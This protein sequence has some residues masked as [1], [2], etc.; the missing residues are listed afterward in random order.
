MNTLRLVLALTA[1]VGSLRAVAGDLTSI[2]RSILK[3]PRYA[4]RSPKYCLLV[5]GPKAKTRIWLVLDGK[6]LYVDRNGNGDLTEAGKRV[7]GKDGVFK[8][9]VLLDPVTGHKHTDLIVNVDR[10]IERSDDTFYI[11]PYEI[12]GR[13]RGKYVFTATPG[14]ADRAKDAPAVPL[15]GPLTPR[16]FGDAGLTLHRDRDTRL[17][18]HLIGMGDKAAIY[19]EYDGIPAEVRPHVEIECPGKT[20]GDGPVRST[21]HLKER[22]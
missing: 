19:V 16:I 6:T 12:T 10:R 2:D 5:L 11:Q 9:G 15:D 14:F 3:E 17:S 8:I 4:S 13:V 22:C 21:T 1:L 7:D 20:K 18:I